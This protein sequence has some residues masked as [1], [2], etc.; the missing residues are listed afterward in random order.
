LTAI[1]KFLKAG[2]SASC[3]LAD[4]RFFLPGLADKK[5]AFLLEGYFSSEPKLDRDSK[6][7]PKE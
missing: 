2:V 6:G 5:I 4:G 3:H 1:P 7:L